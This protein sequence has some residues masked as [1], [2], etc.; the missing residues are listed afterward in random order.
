MTHTVNEVEQ[1]F[2]QKLVG[3]DGSS[4]GTIKDV[5][6]DDATNQPEWL[7]VSTGAL[8]GVSFVPIVEA[9]RDGDDVRVPYDKE[10]VKSAPDAN[11]DGAISQDEERRLY[12]HYGL[13]YS[14][15]RS[16][17]GWAQYDEDVQPDPAPMP[18]APP[19][20]APA[21]VEEEREVVLYE[22]VPVVEKRVVPR[23]RVR[24]DKDTV[25]EQVGVSGEVRKEQIEV[26]GVEHAGRN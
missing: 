24:L 9:H 17:G 10:L 11:A 14:E 19:P 15:H 12:D 16:S 23:E 21:R 6:L 20:P 2:G 3:S 7:V 1:W 8:G 25:T 5:Y 18:V 26:E 22:E 4:I 13:V